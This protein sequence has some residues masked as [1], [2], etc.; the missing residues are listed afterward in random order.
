[1][2]N[3]ND[4]NLPEEGANVTTE[5]VTE[6]TDA[7]AAGTSTEVAETSTTEPTAQPEPLAEVIATEAEAPSEVVAQESVAEIAAQQPEPIA[8]EIAA[9]A[10]APA[11]VVAPEHVAEI[12]ALQPEAA[13]EPTKAHEA[14]DAIL[15]AAQ[16]ELVPHEHE[17]EVQE[18]IENY[19]E[20]TKEQLLE[21]MHKAVHEGDVMAVRNK[22]FAMRDAFS[23]MASME[24]NAAMAKFIE[25]GGN[26]DDFHYNDD[27]T[28]NK[29]YA[30][31]EGYKKKRGEHLDAIEKQKLDNL[32]AKNDI[33]TE[34]KRLIQNEDNMAK[35]YEGFNDLQGKWRS[36]GPVP[37]ANYRDL[38]LTYKLYI[39]RFYE[40]VKIN[41]DLQ[42]LDQKKNL[43][44]KINLCEK[45]EEL[46][47]E[48]NMN[49][50]VRTI[51]D[52]IG[53]WKDIGQV[54]REAKNEVWD[55]F[56]AAIDKVY[57]RRR[58]YDDSMKSSYE[59]NLL[60]KIEL[61]EKADAICSA[62]HDK[63]NLW[64]EV[65]HQV[66]EL[67][68]IWKT[69][70]PASRKE[71]DDVWARFKGVCDNFFKNKNEFYTLRKK[72]LAG[73]LQLKTELCI[74]AEALKD[75]NDWRGTTQ[76]LVRLQDEWKKIGPV[77]EK[78]SQK[79]WARFKAAC[80][81]FFN[82]KKDY[83]SNIDNEQDDNYKKK[84]ELVEA[85]EKFEMSGENVEVLDQLK[86]FQRT[87]MEIGLVPFSKKDELQKRYKTAIDKLYDNL[88]IDE[89]EKRSF[90]A[91]QTNYAAGQAMRG[92]GRDQ[93]GGSNSGHSGG[94]PERSSLSSKIA[95]LT[96]E[97]TVWQ[98][99]IGFF[100]KSKNADTIRQEFE[101]KI[102]QAKK[103]IEELRAKMNAKREEKA[104]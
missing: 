97:V 51:Q 67:Q 32:K 95:A 77:P 87:W 11:E 64:Q 17:E 96:S 104:Q 49:K 54:T 4:T 35:A 103:E 94:S 98:N 34:L 48:P 30:L 86:A 53:Q 37:S 14:E 100:S 7:T 2:E 27:E 70:G 92:G 13:A 12:A 26:K 101:T 38:Q 73:N 47:L 31:F 58:E 89:R 82:R 63:H 43:V 56:K 80:D 90:R 44:L 102:N 5:Q 41:K 57:E 62:I 93:R 24:R 68:T 50:A 99:N 1:M 25:E 23:H 36:I 91:T 88:R 66:V 6:T 16:A 59:A 76:E 55:R 78:S 69:I 22:V 40:F 60:A 20:F 52:L 45:A 10:E 21:S 28:T 39:D 61:C 65:Q 83:F 74:Q 3:V 42:Q 29:F 72:E 75:N 9:E 19:A 18:P 79:V 8:A 15:D 81:E 85:I 71:N 84:L 33:L 46:M